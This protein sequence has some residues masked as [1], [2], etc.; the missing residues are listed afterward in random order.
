MGDTQTNT[1]TLWTNETL[2]LEAQRFVDSLRDE[3]F[4]FLWFFWTQYLREQIVE[5][6]TND[7]LGDT[8]KWGLLFKGLWGLIWL[9]LWDKV[10]V[11]KKE[12]MEHKYP[13]LKSIH[14]STRNQA[15]EV[16][17]Q[18]IATS[19]TQQEIVNLHD[20]VVD[21][22]PKDETQTW[23]HSD[24]SSS[25][26]KPPSTQ[27]GSNA[28]LSENHSID[29]ARWT[30]IPR[31]RV[32]KT[33]DYI[34]NKW[35]FYSPSK[36]KCT[37]WRS[38]YKHVCTTWAWNV[39]HHLTWLPLPNNLEIDGTEERPWEMWQRL[40]AMNC[41]KILDNVDPKHPVPY[42]PKDGDIAVRPR[43]TLTSGRTT[44]HMACYINWHWVSDTIQ[45]R[46]SCYPNQ[47]NEPKVKIY[48]YNPNMNN[49]H[50]S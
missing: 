27:A 10:I 13:L 36:W 28:Q 15:N 21:H 24:S 31:E 49:I 50:Y 48:R 20:D 16:E 6:L 9:P 1:E 2:K 19:A 26:S 25:N 4:W 44:Q 40:N 43:F 41:Y 33:R 42:L 46:M 23:S 37:R 30:E 5:Y 45:N 14:A 11:E 29:S 18:T 34:V 47:P 38:E 17:D 22:N 3:E 35:E 12:I 39:L 7:D 32:K 8:L